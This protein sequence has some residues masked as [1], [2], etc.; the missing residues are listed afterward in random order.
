MTFDAA[1]GAVVLFGGQAGDDLLGDTWTWDGRVWREVT[2]DPAPSPRR[3][4]AMTYDPRRRAV[5]VFGGWDGRRHLGD[6]WA[7]DGA[8]WTPLEAP[9]PAPR[10]T[11]G[12]VHEAARGRV[13]LFG[14]GQRL[15]SSLDPVT[16]IKGPYLGDTWALE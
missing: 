16:G 6:L 3:G 14:G 15:T 4:H 10:K 9:G 11:A 12:L 13:L 1:R 2:V 7:W 5:L 8:R